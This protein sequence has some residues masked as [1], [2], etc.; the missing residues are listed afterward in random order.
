MKGRAMQD[1]R[2]AQM[3]EDPGSVSSIVHRPS[4]IV[5]RPSFV[6]PS[7]LVGLPRWPMM[8]DLSVGDSLDGRVQCGVDLIEVDR[9][10][11]AVEK[12]GERFMR[13]IWTD[14]ELTF[15]R[16]RYPE[17]AARFAGKEA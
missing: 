13:R 16:G 9:I 8:A 6:S 7:A 11:A 14:R 5:H 2:D 3:V 4:S 1:D 10:Q 17:L 15:C 12:W